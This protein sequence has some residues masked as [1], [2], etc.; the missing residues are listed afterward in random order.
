MTQSNP[1]PEPGPFALADGPELR[2]PGG[3]SLD[4]PTGILAP[5]PLPEPATPSE[6]GCIWVKPMAGFELPRPAGE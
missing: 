5:A 6:A 4:L 2:A 1:V 3:L